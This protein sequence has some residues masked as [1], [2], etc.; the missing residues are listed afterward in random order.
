MLKDKR[1]AD[2]SFIEG[3]LWY[4]H[5]IVMGNKRN[6][7]EILVKPS[8]DSYIE[9]HTSVQNSYK[10]LKFMFYWS[11]MKTLVK[12]MMNECDICKKIKVDELPIQAF[13]NLFQPQMVYGET[14]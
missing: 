10:R 1:W 12:K 6:S 7:R 14:L 2:Y 13:C 8:N 3:I 5:K 4:K 11:A 9:R